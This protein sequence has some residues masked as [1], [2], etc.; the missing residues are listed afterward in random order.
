MHFQGFPFCLPTKIYYNV[1]YSF[2]GGG[3]VRY[4]DALVFFSVFG[5]M[6]GVPQ[7]TCKHSILQDWPPGGSQHV[8]DMWVKLKG[9]VLSGQKRSL[10][11]IIF[12]NN[13][14]MM[15][16]IS[17][18]VRMYLLKIDVDLK[19]SYDGKSIISLRRLYISLSAPSTLFFPNKAAA[20]TY[21]LPTSYHITVWIMRTKDKKGLFY[22]QLFATN[23]H[24]HIDLVL[25]VHYVWEKQVNPPASPN[26]TTFPTTEI[27]ERMPPMLD[28]CLNKKSAL[29]HHSILFLTHL[30]PDTPHTGLQFSATNSF[31]LPH[32]LPVYRMYIH[33]YCTHCHR[34]RIRSV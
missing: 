4:G 20:A 2:T 15:P 12:P 22:R 23:L 10:G 27:I 31:G 1:P 26:P 5:S 7:V 8:R 21:F 18:C 6:C 19:T 30:A 14:C 25:H 24:K 33:F 13:F 11:H 16:I 34:L 29:R 28:Q 17:G 9:D 32:Q 3:G